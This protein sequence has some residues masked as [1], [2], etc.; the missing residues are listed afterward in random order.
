MTNFANDES[1]RANKFEKV[2]RFHNFRPPRRRLRG[3]IPSGVFRIFIV[4]RPPRC[5]TRAVNESPYSVGTVGK[6]LGTKLAEMEKRSGR[7]DLSEGNRVC[8]YV[9]IR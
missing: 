8:T 9:G 2:S 7:I 6:A 4:L 1:T 3:P 5:R